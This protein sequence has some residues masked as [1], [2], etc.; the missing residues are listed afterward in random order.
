MARVRYQGQLAHF[1]YCTSVS[2]PSHHQHPSAHRESQNSHWYYQVQVVLTAWRCDY[3]EV[4]PHSALGGQS[5]AGLSVPPCSPASS[6]LRAGFAGGLR[7]GLT[8]AECGCVDILWP[9]RKN[10]P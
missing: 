9:G 5:P 2:Y 8:Q 6:P 7:P 4:R 10:G 3:N 1:G